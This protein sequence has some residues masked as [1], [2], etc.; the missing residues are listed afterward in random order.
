MMPFKATRCGCGCGAV[1]GGAKYKP[2]HGTRD[3]RH[4]SGMDS[5]MVAVRGIVE[6]RRRLA[7]RLLEAGEC[8]HNFS[9][10]YFALYDIVKAVRGDAELEV[11]VQTSESVR[12][13]DVGIPALKVG[14]EWDPGHRYAV[15]TASRSARDQEITNLG[16]TLIHFKKLPTLLEVRLVLSLIGVDNAK[17]SEGPG[18]PAG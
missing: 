14:F 7:Y 8:T 10:D 13:I 2:G 1:T 18:Q 3:G 11:I 12:S 15:S 5:R 17:D 4:W 9:A 6:G 16:W